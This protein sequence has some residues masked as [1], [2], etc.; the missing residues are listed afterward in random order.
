MADLSFLQDQ[1]LCDLIL[2]VFENKKESREHYLGMSEIGEPC[3]RKLWYKF[4]NPDIKEKFDGRIKS[5]FETGHIIEEKLIKAIRQIDYNQNIFAYGEQQYFS[6]LDNQFRGHNDIIVSKIPGSNNPHIVDI[7]TMKGSIFTEFKK[8]G[9][10][11]MKWGSGFKYYSQ[12]QCYMG[13]SGIHRYILLCENKD[14]SELYQYKIKFIHDDF[15]KIKEKAKRIIFSKT[16]PAIPPKDGVFCRYCFWNKE[17]C[18]PRPKNR[19][20]F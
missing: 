14:N 3:E 9:I 4:H 7:K 5:L 18:Q 8:T 1:S 2:Q 17:Y 13:Y 12:A 10:D 20:E 6:D 15:D 19:A 16:P 11:G